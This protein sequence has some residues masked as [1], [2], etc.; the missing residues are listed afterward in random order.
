MEIHPQLRAL[1]SDDAPQRKAQAILY[2][3]MDAW[4]SQP[5][6]SAVHADLERFA[7]G[8]A[9]ADCAALAALF[10][11][12]RP[13]AR[14]F[15]DGFNAA[16]AR[17]LADAPLGHMPFRHFTDGTVSTV[18]L[19][20]ARDVSLMLVAVD[21]TALA[22]APPPVSVSLSP[23]QCHDHVLAGT[24]AAELVEAR[25]TGPATASLTRR[26][27]AFAPGCVLVRDGAR[28]GLLYRRVSGC[29]VSLR[30]VRRLSGGAA[31]REYRLSDGAL[32]H[33]S[34]GHVRDSRLELVATLLG[35]MQRTDAA[36]LLAAMARESGPDGLRW[37]VLRECLGLDTAIGFAALCAIAD[38]DA[39]VG[40]DSLCAAATALRAHLIA[41]HPELES[42]LPCPA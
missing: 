20:G 26:A 28:E 17:A 40:T 15:V 12:A 4:R 25:A 8:A 33:Q 11:G 7:G 35:R 29:L 13:A 19:G 2:R 6:V 30:L 18:L 10:D 23:A 31:G 34:A 37:Q 38:A 14:D 1:R 24:A 9:L 3:A 5:P 41:G 39:G 22:A 16:A 32:L 21:G 36:H 42:L 27:A